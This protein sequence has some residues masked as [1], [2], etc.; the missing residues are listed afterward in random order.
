MDPKWASD[1]LFCSAYNKV[2]MA[3]TDSDKNISISSSVF[4][5]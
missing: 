1:N 4:K 3:C 2:C 5:Q